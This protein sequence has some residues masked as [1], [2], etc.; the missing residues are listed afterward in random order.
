MTDESKCREDHDQLVVLIA[1]FTE[2]RQAMEDR[3]RKLNELREQVMLDRDTYLRSDVYGA[4]HAE[5]QRRIDANYQNLDS[6]IGPLENWKA[7]A[8]GVG[9]ALMFAAGIIGGIIVHLWK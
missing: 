9:S 2:Y 5:L 7:G 1:R 3:L 4:Q 8:I 6:R